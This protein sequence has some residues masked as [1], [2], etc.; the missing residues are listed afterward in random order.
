MLSFLNLEEYRLPQP[1]TK[2]RIDEDSPEHPEVSEMR[3]FKLLAALNPSKACGPD[4]IPNWMLK[5]YAELLSFPISRI[6]NLS[7]KEQ[8]LPKIWKF[9]DVSPLPKVKPVEDLKKQLRPISLTPCLSKVAEECVVHDYVKPAV[10]DVLDPSQYGAVP[11]S[12]TTQALIHMLHNWSKET[13]GNGATVRTIHFDDKKAFD[14]IDHRILVEKL[15]RLNLPTRIINWII[16]FLSN[17]SQRI[18]LSEGCYSEWGSVPSEVPQGTKLGPWLFLVLINDLD[19][20]NLANVWKYVD[21]TTASEVVV[22]GNRSHAQ[23]IADK[24]AEWSTQKRVKLNSDKCKELRISFAKDEPQFASIVVDDKELERTS[25]RL[26]GLIIS[27]NLTWNEHIS[28]VIKK[29]SKRLYFLVQLKRSRV[30]RQ[31]MSTFYTA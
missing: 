22:K 9:A 30:P 21:D 2:L 25:A 24:V 10:L 11:N 23:E 13:D 6:I 7:L 19:V 31:D 4:K 3:I 14:F 28:D 18:K 29:A 1:L 12:S 16:D 15:C 26:L 27:S 20:D 8:S 17:R 5:E